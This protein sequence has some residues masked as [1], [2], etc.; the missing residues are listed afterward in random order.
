MPGESCLIRS[1]SQ[2]AKCV[3]FLIEK[4]LIKDGETFF[5]LTPDQDAPEKI[6]AWIMSK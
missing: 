1:P 6:S 3:S 5:S 4:G 2:M